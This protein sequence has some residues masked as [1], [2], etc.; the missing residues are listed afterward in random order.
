MAARHSRSSSGVQW[1]FGRLLVLKKNFLSSA[2]LSSTS[3]KTTATPT[4]LYKPTATS[5]ATIT[6]SNHQLHPTWHPKR[7]F[8]QSLSSESRICLPTAESKLKQ[9]SKPQAGHSEL[10]FNSIVTAAILILRANIAS[11]KN[12]LM[13]NGAKNVWRKRRCK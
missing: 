6:G 10:T 11:E 9:F 8:C 1:T 4:I 5:P 12:R 13:K 2:R 3:R 7:C